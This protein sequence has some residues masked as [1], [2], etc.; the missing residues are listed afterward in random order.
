MT[1]FIASVDLRIIG[2]RARL[3]GTGDFDSLENID[4]T[5]LPNGATCW[6]I[7]QA[8]F[9]VLHKDSVIV[10]APPTSIAP[11]SGPGRWIQFSG[12]GGPA[13]IP[14]P[15]GTLV[16]P[17]GAN[18]INELGLG[19]FRPSAGL[20]GL[21]QGGVLSL[22]MGDGTVTNVDPV[23]PATVRYALEGFNRPLAGAD[24]TTFAY[25][26]VDPSVGS[27]KQAA[28]YVD[29]TGNQTANS[30]PAIR[31]VHAGHGAGVSVSQFDDGT[32]YLAQS[33]AD[34]SRGFSAIN[35][36]AAQAAKALFYAEWNQA[37][38]PTL[39]MYYA[40]LSTANALTIQRR[41]A[42]AVDGGTQ[43]RVLEQGGRQ[44]FG[45][46]NDGA[47]A[48]SGPV[49][50]VGTPLQNS[51]ELRLFGSAFSGGVAHDTEWLL[52]LV[53]TGLDNS[54]LRFYHISNAGTEQ[55]MWLESDGVGDDPILHIG[56]ADRGS[57]RCA[58]VQSPISLSLLTGGGQLAVRLDDPPGGPGH[59]NETSIQTLRL[60]DGAGAFAAKLVLQGAPDSAGV[61]FRALVVANDGTDDTS[62]EAADFSL[63]ANWG[64]GASVSVAAGSTCRR[65]ACTITAAGAPSPGAVATL[66]FDTAFAA[67]PFAIAARTDANNP[68][69]VTSMGVK[70]LASTTQ[71]LLT[72]TGSCAPT[73][74]TSY[75]FTWIV[76]E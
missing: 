7:D 35:G 34:S 10:P 11:G 14:M 71:L 74:G 20:M 65:G 46:Y 70:A 21:A 1:D 38:T 41:D 60:L 24:E 22:Q 9:Y 69:V 52:Q 40:A 27:P 13:S 26:L 66:T 57:V 17:E 55:S 63:D 39:G 2:P 43:I 4:T 31:I 76:M 33:F 68:P 6:V 59:D 15:D 51:P 8:A 50:T 18:F 56:V 53:P 67:T 23:T 48:L 12:G 32:A 73:A 3:L 44:R 42:S 75:D 64:A 45:V 49:S 36:A 58:G 19:L 37:E 5:I 25:V 30:G 29:I 54:E 16:L 28:F 61:G 47:A 72:L 62:V